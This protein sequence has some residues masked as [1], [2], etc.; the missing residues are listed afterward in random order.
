MKIKSMKPFYSKKANRTRRQKGNAGKF[1]LSFE[2]LEDRRMLAAVTVNT[3]VDLVDGNTTTIASLI[4]DPGADGAVSLRE[5]LAAADNSSITD[6]ITFDADVFNGEAADVIRLQNQLVVFQSVEIDGGDLGIVVSG[7]SS[8]ND[9]TEAESF[10]TDTVASDAAGLLSD[11]T[12]RVFA[13]VGAPGGTVSISG[14]TITGGVADG[15]GGGILVESANL[16]LN[17]SIVSGNRSTNSGGGIEFGAGQLTIDQSTISGNVAQSAGSAIAT[18]GGISSSG[19]DIV[20]SSST[21]SGNLADG[22][23][24]Q[25]G[26][27]YSIAGSLSFVSSTVS[28]NVASSSN[29]LS[30]GGGILV[31]SQSAFITDSTITENEADFGGGISIGSPLAAV[32][33]GLENSI[34]AGNTALSASADIAAGFTV[35]FDARSSLI[36]DNLGTSLVATL[37][38]ADS[39]GNLIGTTTAPLDPLLGSLADNGGLTET[40]ALL[41]GSP[42][43]NAGSSS[44]DFDQ[45]GIERLSGSRADIGA[46]E[47]QGPVLIVDTNEGFADDD[48]SAGNFSLAEAIILSNSTP[49]IET[50]L[51]DPAVFDRQ[52]AV[53]IRLQQELFII[54]SVTIDASDLDV[55][56]SGDTFRNDILL[57]GTSITDTRGNFSSFDNVRPFNINTNIGDTVTLRGLTIT[58]GVSNFRGGGIESTSAALVIDD[59]V[60]SGNSSFQSGGGISVDNG[61]LI[62]N[63]SVISDNQAEDFAQAGGGVSANFSDVTITSSTVSGNA[64]DQGG[65]ISARGGLLTIVNSSI[66]RNSSRDVGGGISASGSADVI[67]DRSTVNNNFSNFGGGGGIFNLSGSLAVTNSTVSGNAALNSDGGGI[68]STAA[69]VNITDSTITGNTSSDRGNGITIRSVLGTEQA[70][71]TVNNSIIA[72]NSGFNSVGDIDLGF[73]DFGPFDPAAIV[74]RSSLVGNNANSS[75]LAAPIGSPDV[76]GNIIGDFSSPIDPLLGELADNGGPT[77][78]H[79]LLAGSP[80]IDTGDNVFSFDQRGEVRP[81]A[82]GRG[83]DIG[84]YEEQTLTLLVDTSNDLIDGDFS[85]GNQSLREA[86]ER[87]NASEGVDRIFFDPQVFDGDAEDIIRLVNGELDITEGLVI[88]TADMQV[89]VSGDSLGNDVFDVETF[90][91]DIA[92]SDAIGSLDDNSRV[93]NIATSAG[94]SVS[95]SGLT[96]TGGI[97]SEGGGGIAASFATLELA[98][99]NI[100]GNRSVGG[101]GGIL[102]DSLLTLDDSII[103]G[104][105]ALEGGGIAGGSG[106]ITVSNSTVSDNQ[107]ATFGGGIYSTTGRVFL[108]SSVVEGNTVSFSGGGIASGFSPVTLTDSSVINNVSNFQGGGISSPIGGVILTGS[109][110]SGNQSVTSGGGIITTLGSVS[111]TESTISGNSATGITAN[112]G[113]IATQSGSISL[114]VSTVGNNQSGSDGGGLFSNSGD[115]IFN[116]STLSGN[117]GAGRGGGL[118]VGGGETSIISSTLSG[119]TAGGFGGGIFVGTADFSILDSTVAFNESTLVEG[120]GGLFNDNNVGSSTFEIQNT[121][122]ASN[123]AAGIASDLRFNADDSLDLVS[124]LIGTNTSTTL[125]AAPVGSPDANGNLIGTSAMVIDP[126]LDELSDYGGLTLTHALLNGSP[127]IDSGSSTANSDQRGNPFVRDAGNAIDIGAFEFQRLELVVNATQDTVDNEFNRQL[128]LREAVLLANEN[129]GED[130]INFSPIQFQGSRFNDTI[131]LRL[132]ELT[133]SESLHIDG[134]DLGIVISGDYFRNDFNSVGDITDLE[135]TSDARLED[136]FS[137]LNITAASGDTVTLTGLT[138]TGGIGEFGGISN[139]AADLVISQS[140]ISGNR[141]SGSGGGISNDSGVLTIERSTISGNQT[142]DPAASGGGIYS[143]DGDVA[144]SFSTISGNQTTGSIADG[145]GIYTVDG[146]ISLILSTVSGNQ[147][148]GNLANGGGISSGGGDLLLNSV[149]VTQN[150]TSRLG[151]GVFI[152]ESTSNPTVTLS[153]TIVAGN[154]AATGQPDLRFDSNGLVNIQFSLIGDNTGTSLVAAPIGSPDANGNLIG[155]A[156][157]VIDPL[158]GALADNNGSTFTHELLPGSPAIDMG[159]SSLLTDQR[160]NP[161]LMRNDGGGVDIGSFEQIVFN[162]VVDNSSDVDDGDRSAGNLSLREALSLSN[163]NSS[164]DTISFDPAVFNGEPAD[165]I[166]LLDTLSISEGVIIDAAELGIV[167]SGDTAGNDVLVAGSNVTDTFAS[168]T[169]DT[170]VDNVQVIDIEAPAGETVFITG[171]I[172]T[173]GAS[174][175]NGGGIRNIDTDLV[176]TSSS[177]VGNRS[178]NFREGGGIYS[179][180]G[181][182]TLNDST[183]S[184]NFGDGNG[185]GIHSRSGMVTLNDSFVENNLSRRSGGGIYSTSGDVLL[186][187]SSVSNNTNVSNGDGGGIYNDNGDITLVDSSASNNTTNSQGGGI[188]SSEGDVFLD[189]SLIEN[190]TSTSNGGGIYSGRDIVT[191]VASSLSN[192]TSSNDGGGIFVVSGFVTLTDTTVSSNSAGESGD[193][194][195][196]GTNNADVTF[197]RS[198]ISNNDSG[199]DGGGV[200]TFIGDLLFLNSTV[201]GNVSAGEGGGLKAE[202]SDEIHFVNSTVTSNQSSGDGG[203]IHFTS[204]SFTDTLIVENS[205]V[206]ENVSLEG[207]GPD[208][209]FGSA[210][211]SIVSFS[212]IGSNDGTPLPATNPGT[213]DANGNLIGS[214]ADPIDPLLGRLAN[215]GGPTLTHGLLPSSPA[216]NAGGATSI[217]V[218]TIDQRGSDRILEG[219]VDIGAFEGEVSQIAD[220]IL[221][222]SDFSANFVDAIDGDGINAGNGLGFSLVGDQ[223]LTSLPWQNLNTIYLQFLTDVSGSLEDGDIFLTGTNGGDYSLGPI[224]FDTDTLVATV[225]IIGGIDVDSLVISIFENTVIDSFGDPVIGNDGGQFNFNFNVLPGDVDGNGQVNAEDTFEVFASN[226]DLTIPE[227]ARRDIDGSGQI[228]TI[229]VF[230]TFANDTNGLPAVPTAPVPSA[231]LTSATLATTVDAAFSDDVLVEEPASGAE[232]AKA[233]AGFDS[234]VAEAPKSNSVASQG[235]TS[236]TDKATAAKLDS[237]PAPSMIEPSQPVSV[238]LLSVDPQPRA[239]STAYR[240]TRTIFDEPVRLNSS[241]ELTLAGNVEV[242]ATAAVDRDYFSVEREFVTQTD[243]DLLDS[244]FQEVGSSDLELGQIG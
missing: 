191:V 81:N 2:A 57:P 243:L 35:A 23:S 131:F 123:T 49:E 11:N 165:V 199:A 125:T 113:G 214:E 1:G 50:I 178:A 242:E 102:T 196:V 138:I 126:L 219:Q 177:I 8:G 94:E 33:I 18:G 12:N 24:G 87:A 152:A 107:A 53:V 37:G 139:S 238:P 45:R 79:A 93:F 208:L 97:T 240:S 146:S 163:A 108:N 90:I 121:I 51:F 225:P 66:S 22:E 48:T 117:S 143:N 161:L 41:D 168:E 128:T 166:R 96:I 116:N 69:N 195:G 26:G 148:L 185:G 124:S 153:N 229:D 127:A 56:I 217:D 19:G 46:F 169:N 17:Q 207:I 175:E 223:Q 236:K 91:V 164:I 135:N 162:L 38:T 98:D 83:P 206:A 150:S 112:G 101:G 14:L 6:T 183:V 218:G 159:R 212:L 59:S 205:I 34:V 200:Y 174:N 82:G 71:L 73:D 187:N 47:V 85:I 179:D 182:L 167:I 234:A 120:S 184:E 235:A 134:E 25:G 95:I 186:T 193:G 72:G 132:G 77:R 230:A 136:N 104:N 122:I 119:N 222:S 228:N 7:D 239:S 65:G 172:V 86:I 100:S 20:V 220:V 118:F 197:I 62:V 15:S 111:L 52:A 137:V 16:D 244:V 68:L 67:L 141:G 227:N 84:A 55:V 4:A 58:G 74:I 142:L 5:A 140:D 171:L 194:G 190:N 129:P 133:V 109:T 130:L 31:G 203:G 232:F 75:L 221:S 170:L 3:A 144:I 192:N 99:V 145:G 88:D 39:D 213:P 156:G 210:I 202:L 155:S 215:N 160:A 43:L 42:G 64:A 241:P 158:L 188:Y 92:A 198:T 204:T 78:T 211:E 89:V 114:T 76:N 226:T 36:G 32:T 173:G 40:H 176:L 27:V 80:A 201:S 115:V 9:Q 189:N 149:T 224:S 13:F 151:G 10:V 105:S 30:A 60:V 181:Q 54:Q 216:I 106:V 157:A 21:I 209:T 103:S 70:L 231:M 154:E 28:G 61:S 233:R 180:S 110:V 147:T 63:N 44:L 29:G 237:K